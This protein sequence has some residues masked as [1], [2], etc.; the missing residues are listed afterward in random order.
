MRFIALGLF[1]L[2][3]WA[4]PPVPFNSEVN[5]AGP[6]RL[7]AAADAITVE[8][9][10]GSGRTWQAVFS[11]DPEKPLITRIGF[12]G[13]EP[14]VRDAAPVYDGEFGRRRG[15]WDE[16]FD[17]P[18][19]APE[20]TRRNP[21][22][23]QLTAGRA[24]NFGGRL[25]LSFDTFRMGP[26]QG[27]IAFTFYPGSRLIQMEAVASTAEDNLAYYYNAGIVMAEPSRAGDVMDTQ[28][29]YFD[30]AGTFQTLRSTGPER[31]ALKVRYRAIA[32]WTPGGSVVAFPPPHQYFMPRDFSTNLGF[33][34][35]LAWQGRAAI[36]I[37]QYPDDNSPFYPWMNAP[38]HTLQRMSLFLIVDD[39]DARAGLTDVLR[40]THSDRFPRVEGYRTMAA[41]WHPDFTVQAMQNGSDWVPPFKPVLK[42]MGVDAMLIC[43]FHLEGNPNSLEPVRLQELAALYKA[44]RAQSD[45]NFLIIPGEEPN[46]WLGGHYVAVFPKPVY[47]FKERPKGTPLKTSDAKYGTV[48]HVGSAEELMQMVH[49]EGGL[50]YQAHPRTKGSKGFPDAIRETSWFRDS[51]FL[52]TG[53]KA[54]P[55]DL[56]SP[57]LGERAFKVIDEINNWGL[58][59]LYIGEVDLFQI[60]STHELYGH[61]NVNYLRMPQ[62]PDS[63]HYGEA[64][65]A[66][67]TGDSFLSTGE[68]LLPE[69]KWSGSGA[70]KIAVEATVNWTFPLRLAEI[71]WGDGMRTERKIVPLE[72]TREFG[73]SKFTWSADVSGWKWAR[74][75]VWDV[76][77]NGAFT[78]PSVAKP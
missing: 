50:V 56:S 75:A 29:S 5:G 7:A 28:V 41:H 6:A 19:Q 78:Q 32:L 60:D 49:E 8:W 24:R 34:W 43:D 72:G 47:W 66:M 55:S 3:A 18:Y 58:H 68:V 63:D 30:T 67:T 2:F 16:F 59:K 73:S 62:L 12:A 17:N 21:G 20:G 74:L 69:V 70:G 10:D 46:T 40:Y 76:A 31:N 64:L 35:H 45:A 61:M 13:R 57:R 15:G 14:V 44:T 23:L 51:R 36:G 33:T 48:W 71:V 65:Q 38:P 25:E 54:M 4:A 11:R 9:P 37:R 52:G 53:W 77:G 39:R 42:A 22:S 27:S 26:F 1:P